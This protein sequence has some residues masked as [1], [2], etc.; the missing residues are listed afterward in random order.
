MAVLVAILVIAMRVKEIRSE[1]KKVQF[2]VDRGSNRRIGYVVTKLRPIDR[3]D[4]FNETTTMTTTTTIKIDEEKK[5]IENSTKIDR[6]TMDED[7]QGEF[8]LFFFN[9]KRHRCL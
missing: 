9:L 5:T 3:K 7:E 2:I 1:I 4:D 8:F 6:H